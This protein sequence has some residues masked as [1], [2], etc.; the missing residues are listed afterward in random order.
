MQQSLG[1]RGNI[2][3]QLVEEVDIFPSLVDLGGFPVPADLMGESWVP[4]LQKSQRLEGYPDSLLSVTIASLMG[5]GQ[6]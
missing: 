3:E 6:P 1:A 5:M 2:I 4:L